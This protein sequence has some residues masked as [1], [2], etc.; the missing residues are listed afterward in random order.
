MKITIVGGGTAGWVNALILANHH[1]DHQFTI[2]EFLLNYSMMDIIFLS[3]TLF[4]RLM[5]LQNMQLNIQDGLLMLL[6]HT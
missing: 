6:H 2:P 4:L 3:Q 1:L 5:Q